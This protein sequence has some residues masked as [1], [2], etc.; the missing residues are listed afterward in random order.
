MGADVPGVKTHTT[1]D[2]LTWLSP[3]V[4]AVARGVAAGKNPTSRSHS[5]VSRQR[6]EDRRCERV[7]VAGAAGAALGRTIT[8]GADPTEWE[9]HKGHIMKE[10]LQPDSQSASQPLHTKH[11]LG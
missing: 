8:P 11:T 10:P 5:P 7:Q 1:P 6:Q 3:P 2:T 4:V 9:C